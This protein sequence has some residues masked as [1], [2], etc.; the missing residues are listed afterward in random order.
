MHVAFCVWCCGCVCVCVC[1]SEGYG[2]V[3]VLCVVSMCVREKR[4][5]EGRRLIKFLHSNQSTDSLHAH[6]HG[7][8]E[9][10]R[11]TSEK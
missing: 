11:S 4:E 8:R 7:D 6:I 2:Y 1:V 10:W 5:R 3:G 9:V